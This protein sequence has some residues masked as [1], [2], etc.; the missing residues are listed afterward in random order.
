MIPAGAWIMKTAIILM[1]FLVLSGCGLMARKERQEQIAAA[2]SARDQGFADCKGQYP[3]SKQYVAKEACDAAAAKVIRPFAN[4]PDLFDRYW[5]TRGLVAERLQASKMTPAEAALELAQ[6]D[7]AIAEDE[8][9][10][11]LA[12]RSVS[13]Q[14]AVAAAASGPTICNRIGNTTICN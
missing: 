10:R 7:S 9:R 6:S 11:N 13:A 2:R 4:Y 14:E 3:G 1:A 12:N 5:A 8:Q